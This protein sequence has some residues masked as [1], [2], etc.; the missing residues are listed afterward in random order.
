MDHNPEFETQE[1]PAPPAPELGPKP[2]KV[3]SENPI[4]N[5]WDVFLLAI[6]QFVIPFVVI[7]PIV[8]LVAAK[9]LY[10]TLTF[11]QVAQ[12]KLW[13]ALCTQFAWYVVVLIYMVMFIEG[14]YR[15]RFWD[16]I[17]WK[18]PH[19]TWQFLVPLGMVL[20]LLQ[21]MEKFFRMPKHIPMQEYLKT[22][23]IAILTAIFAVS[24]GPLMEELFFRG[25]LYPVLARRWGMFAAISITSI[26]FGLIHSAQ[27]A[28]SPG[29]VLIV[30]LVG[31]V[32]TIVRAK[33]GSVGSSLVVHISYNSTLV[34]LGAIASRHGLTP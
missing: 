4:W 15:R 29:L 12:Q 11:M 6:I 13:I 10:P 27:L 17:Q 3:A 5:G 8:V 7:I 16:A 1:L 32:L 34:I 26:A 22:P 25:F 20:V 31:L 21:G 14:T 23:S 33:T 18:W 2:S 28:F 19:K 30:F 24:L 9:T